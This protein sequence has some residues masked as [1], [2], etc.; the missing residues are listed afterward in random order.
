MQALT[1]M[2]DPPY[3]E[4]ALGLAQRIL[5][6]KEDSVVA[7]VEYAFRLAVSRRSRPA[8]TDHLV[9]VFLRERKRF[10]DN[11]SQAAT[12]VSNEKGI[13]LAPGINQLDLAAWFCVATIL[14]NLDET[15]TKG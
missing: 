5:N 13:K 1:L 8:E 10:S 14:L 3:V 9:E 15:I 12:I 4:M 7:K 6:S 2:N 11:P